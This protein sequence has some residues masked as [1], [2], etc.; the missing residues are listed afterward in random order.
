MPDVAKILELKFCHSSYEDP[1]MK[2]GDWHIFL[3]DGFMPS[4]GN[5]MLVGK[6]LAWNANVKRYYVSIVG[7]TDGAYEYHVGQ[8]LRSSYCKV[9]RELFCLPVAATIEIIRGYINEALA[10]LIDLVCDGQS[11]P[12]PVG[13]FKI[14]DYEISAGM[15]CPCC[16]QDMDISMLR[17]M[18]LIQ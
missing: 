17:E 11:L 9:S 16:R 18:G 13:T 7:C 15:K 1:I 8:E 14:P 5:T 10:L 3:E 2:I 6:L 12:K 4:A